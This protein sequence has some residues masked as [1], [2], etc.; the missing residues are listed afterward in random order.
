VIHRRR[1]SRERDQ[2]EAPCEYIIK[3]KR[4]WE[5]LL[6]YEKCDIIGMTETWQVYSHDWNVK[7]AS[8]KLFRKERVVKGIEEVELYIK[9]KISSYR[10][11]EPRRAG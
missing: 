3:S 5:F 2:G 4:N 10:E 8:Y 1:L 11:I 6:D 7:I 9:D